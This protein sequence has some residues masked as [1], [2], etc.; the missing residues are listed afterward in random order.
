[1]PDCQEIIYSNDYADYI[2]EI[3]QDLPDL[4]EVYGELCYENIAGRLGV[5]HVPRTDN[6][7]ELWEAYRSF[8]KCY[9]LLDTSHLEAIGVERLR[10]QPFLDLTGQGVILGIVDTGIDYTHPAFRFADGSSRI[11]ELWDQTIPHEERNA[12]DPE[13][14]TVFGQEQI[15]AALAAEDPYELVPSRDEEGHGTFL[16]GVAAGNEIPD[17]NFSGVAPLADLAVVKL[18]QAKPYLREYY[19]IPEEAPCYQETDLILGVSWLI[20]LSIRRQQP[21]VI[22]LALG[23][24]QGGHEGQSYLA[25]Q[26]RANHQVEGRCVCLAAGN[27][28]GR[29]HHYR[30]FLSEAE[31]IQEVEFRVAEGER[32]FI[33]ELWNEIPDTY[34]IG[35]TTPTGYTTGRLNILPGQIQRLDFAFEPVVV[36]V[37]YE[38]GLRNV[39]QRL[40]GVRFLDPTPGLWKM[41]I[42]REEVLRGRYDLWLP[43]EPFLQTDTRFVMPDPDTTICDPGNAL[44]TITTGAYNHRSGGIDIHSSRGYTRDH[45][46]KPDLV[47]PGVDILGPAPGIGNLP[48]RYVTRSGTSIAAAET[49]G[50]SA[51]LLE[52]DPE[53]SGRELQQYLI[54][55]ARRMDRSYPNPE[56]GYGIL[57][58]YRTL[59]LMG[60]KRG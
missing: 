21:L 28:V 50:V 41:Q 36:E 46:I 30:G 5:I 12:A 17:N 14:G 52:Y 1:M 24:N 27:E 22:L 32:G 16:T 10:R 6:L 2:V 29:G 59:E 56:W 8:P 4:L 3:E 60:G 38:V 53:R 54:R 31:R 39:G 15:R 43:I 33:L 47:A 20:R 19:R 13:Y 26:L 49:A 44:E 58:V 9:G 42:Y 25:F 55:G 40:T 34:A 57:D 7:P 35:F 11:L 18:K 37:A 23:T 45:E 48:A 51:L